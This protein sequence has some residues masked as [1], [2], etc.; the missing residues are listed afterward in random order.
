[1]VYAPYAL[2]IVFGLLIS[3]TIYFVCFWPSVEPPDD[4]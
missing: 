3:L 4:D 1:M 2:A